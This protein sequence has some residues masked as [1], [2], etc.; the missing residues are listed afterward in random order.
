MN[1]LMAL[2]QLEVTGAE[3]YGVT[4]SNELIKRGNNVTIVSDT[5]TKKFDGEYIKIEF[6]KRGLFQRINQVISLL[7]IIKEKDIQVVHAHSRASSWSCEIACKIAKIPLITTTHGRQPVHLSRKIFKA[8]GR[9]TITVC[10]NIKKHLINE[11]GVDKNKIKV[12]RNP[13]DTSYYPFVYSDLKKDNKIVSIIG[14]LSGPKGEVAYKVLET[15]ENVSNISIQVIGGKEIPEKFNKFLNKSNIKFLGYVNDIPEKIKN[16]D[17][18]I[19]AGRVGVEAILSG[20]PLIAIGEAQYIG[21]VSPDNL[22][23][24]LE[25]N[26]GDI[27]FENK[28]IFHWDN[29]LEDIEKGF[30]LSKSELLDLGENIQTEFDLNII[31]EKIE[32]IYAR[33]YVLTKKYEIPVIMYHRVIR[34]KSEGG[35]HGIYVTESQFEKH[36]KYLKQKGFETITFKDLLNNKYKD[37]FNRGKK[38]IILT[39]DDGYTDNYNYA[40]PLLKKYG[41]KCV[42]YLLSHLNYNKWDVEVKENP[43]HKFELMDMSMIKEMEE[44]GIEFGGHTKT[45]PKLATLP[46]EIAQEEILTSK[47]V[48]EE[49]LGHALISFAYPYGNLNEDVKKIVKNSGYNFAVAT[50]SGDISFSEDLFQIRRIG[51]FSTNNFFTFKRKVSGKYN[52]IKIKREKKEKRHI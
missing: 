24:A 10:E 14:R 7:K 3:V 47:K 2:S 43:E 30:L 48:L 22:I 27:N 32:N 16:S 50:D 19:G 17:L 26:F 23:P 13:I 28:N 12:L 5:L 40:F 25:S 4:L 42:I 46:I 36:L 31:V 52:F 38:Q 29:L 44:Y 35:V 11:L 6:N 34:D 18:V 37:R 21:L 9:E 41:F 39:F 1:I 20:K 33:N 8:F 49:K 15:L 45:H 51:I